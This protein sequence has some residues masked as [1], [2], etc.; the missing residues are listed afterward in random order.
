VTVPPVTLPPV[1]ATIPGVGQLQNGLFDCAHYLTQQAAQLAMIL[2]PRLGATLDPDKDGKACPLLP[3]GGT[4]VTP[5]VGGGYVVTDPGSGGGTSNGTGSTGTGSSGSSAG[6]AVG[7]GDS[8]GSASGGVD[9]NATSSRTSA[10]DAD[11]IGTTD[12]NGQPLSASEPLPSGDGGDGHVVL[13]VLAFLLLLGVGVAT[14]R[15]G[16]LDW[17]RA[18]A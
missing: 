4:T 13:E 12:V 2:D 17:L 1:P 8:G 18:R 11:A 7:T 3:P 14:A 15:E 10:A 9:G 6:G 16:A 5:V